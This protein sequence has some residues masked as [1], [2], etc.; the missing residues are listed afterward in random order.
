MV[1]IAY[2]VEKKKTGKQKRRTVFYLRVDK[3]GI[4]TQ[5]SLVYRPKELQI[6]VIIN[7]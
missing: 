5:N 7:I 6:L 4:Y 2:C 3:F 1:G